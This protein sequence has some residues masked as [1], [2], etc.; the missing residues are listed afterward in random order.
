MFNNLTMSNCHSNARYVMSTGTLQETVRRQIQPQ[1]A[2]GKKINGK[3]FLANLEALEIGPPHPQWALPMLALNLP[4][5]S[6]K[7]LEKPGP[8]A[9]Q[10][11][12]ES[13]SQ[14]TTQR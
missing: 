1:L 2:L 5:K 12:F 9:S 4:L 6:L 8:V 7:T 11:S 14:L 3:Q 10:N 13:L